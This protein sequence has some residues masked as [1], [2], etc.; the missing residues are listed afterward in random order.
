MSLLV[1]CP[2]RG[3]PDSIRAL[4]EAWQ[5]TSAVAELL[6]V[7]DADDPSLPE[8]LGLRS[9]VRIEV[10][11]VAQRLGPIL[12]AFAVPAA[13][14][15]DVIGF[16]GDDNRPRT[17]G[18]DSALTGGLTDRPG[19][20]YGNDLIQGSKLPTSAVISASIIRELGYM[21]PPPVTHLFLDDFWRK[22]GEDIGCLLYF[23]DV[24][25]EHLHPA[26]GKAQWDEGYRQNNASNQYDADR[27][28][29]EFFLENQWPTDLTRLRK[30]L[31][32]PEP[33]T[34]A[35]LRER[36]LVEPRSLARLRERFLLA[37]PEKVKR[38]RRS[39]GVRRRAREATVCSY[40]GI[41]DKKE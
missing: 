16:M 7:V 27:A 11:S 26:V 20:A 38:I 6:V 8:Y 18:W 31:E 37:E 1:I 5:E 36:F 14:N 32:L 30:R 12:N 21:C 35:Q 22:L 9:Q 4:H 13:N 24:I 25:I 40:P 3:R 33:G 23:P 10:N 41:P 19:V 2:S 34:L 15:Y 28:A 39:L 29:L 17:P